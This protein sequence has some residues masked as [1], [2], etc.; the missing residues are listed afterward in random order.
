MN[1]AS[2]VNALQWKQCTLYK[3]YQS[4]STHWFPA[5]LFCASDGFCG[6][7]E[8]SI[9]FAKQAVSNWRAKQIGQI[10]IWS[11]PQA[12][13]SSVILI[14]NITFNGSFFNR[15]GTK[16][17]PQ[18]T[19][20]FPVV[21][22][23]CTWMVHLLCREFALKWSSTEKR[24][25]KAIPCLKWQRANKIFHVAQQIQLGRQIPEER[26]AK[27]LECHLDKPRS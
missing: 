6:N 11:T 15:A 4:S 27:G 2:F 9:I 23:Q 25:N 8:M 10:A 7:W 21:S 1:N 13:R 19:I 3:W 12:G 18:A 16:Y 17:T 22:V 26:I 20:K 24:S 14:L 5:A